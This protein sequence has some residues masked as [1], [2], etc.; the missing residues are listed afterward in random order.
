MAVILCLYKTM[1]K[2]LEK[3]NLCHRNC[4][5]NRS[6]NQSGYCGM[7][8]EIKI[9]RAAL[10]FWEEPCIS[11]TEGSG[12]VFFSGCSLRCIYCQNHDIAIGERGIAITIDRLV[13]IFL[14][15]QEKGAN[16][17]NLVTPGHFI[18]QIKEALIRAKEIG[19]SVPIVYNTG[20]YETVE[21]LQ[22]LD[23]LID[24]YL[25]DFKY[26]D[27]SLAKKYSNAP[28]YPQVAKAAIDEM[29]RQTGPAVFAGEEGDSLMKRG[30]IARH[31]VLPG[32]L[33][34]SKQV[35][36][37]L[38]DTY[39]N[40]IYISLMNQYTPLLEGNEYPNLKR[41][42]TEAEFDEVFDYLCKIGI[43]QGYVQ[44]GDTAEE[45]F[46]PSFDGEGVFKL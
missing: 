42:V 40:Q 2:Q 38:Y 7:T 29:V 15:L 35:L 26:M 27:A 4:G 21:A 9:A 8:N 22:M 1:M 19:L 24:I 11:G 31:L 45:S 37:Y 14:E 46:I 3:C 5:I 41:K 6:D 44:E 10:H 13:E 18:P 33:E 34:N 28:D 36:K 39:G 23:G 20:S 30:T 25:P 32:E 16:N 12:A 43:E 17:I